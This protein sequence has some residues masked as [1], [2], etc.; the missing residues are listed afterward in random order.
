[1]NQKAGDGRTKCVVLLKPKER[2]RL[3][4]LVKAGTTA[5]YKIRHANVLRA[6][7]QSRGGPAL[8]DERAAAALARL[9]HAFAL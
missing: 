1:M 2:E 3:R 6:V 5:A 7:D 9:D 8:T 4:G